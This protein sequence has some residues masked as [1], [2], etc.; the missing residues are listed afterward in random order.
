MDRFRI[1]LKRSR[2][3]CGE[4][5]EPKEQNRKAPLGKC[6]WRRRFLIKRLLLVSFF[7]GREDGQPVVS[8][9]IG[10]HAFAN[11]FFL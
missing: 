2:P 4:H 9:R 10:D 6:A 7:L 1:D 11:T 5:G 3:E 8:M